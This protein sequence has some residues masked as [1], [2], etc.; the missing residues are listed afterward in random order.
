MKALILTGSPHMKGTTSF[1]ADE[2]ISAATE[3]GNE[4]VRFDTAKLD[5]H[6]CTGCMHCRKNDGRCVFDDDMQEIYPHLLDADAVV[7]VTPLEYS[8]CRHSEECR[9]TGSMKEIYYGTEKVAIRKAETSDAAALI[10]YLNIIGGES[11]FLTF[12]PGEFGRSVEAEAVFIENALKKKNA[13]FLVAE[14]AERWSATLTFQEVRGHGRHIPV[15]SESV[16]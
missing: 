9:R 3:A 6:P 13:L 4:T 11:D 7:L 2:F 10:E 1:L 14:Q 16:Y 15:S 12:G 8:T 5:I